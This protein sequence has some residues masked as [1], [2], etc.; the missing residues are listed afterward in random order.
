MVLFDLDNTLS[1][2]SWSER[3]ALPG[4][5]DQFGVDCSGESAGRYLAV[6]KQLAAPL[7]HRLERGELQLDTLN[8][9]RF[10]LFVAA[11]GI[12]VD[13]ALL[14]PAYLG[15]LSRS[16]GLLPGAR[17]LLDELHGE[18]RLGV[19]TNG[20]SAVQ[21]PRLANFDLEKYFEAVVISSEI[22][23]AKPSIDFFAVAFD[24]LGDP[25]PGSVLVVGDS[26]SS[27]IAGG[28]NAGTATC[29]FNPLGA[30]P[31]ATPTGPASSGLNSSG[32]VSCLDPVVRLAR[33]R[34]ARC[35]LAR[36]RLA[37]TRLA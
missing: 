12:D 23:H 24:Q 1:D 31:P 26:L 20:Y 19:V 30:P 6:F 36:C 18:V 14:A 33:C 3:E 21:R 25:D 28:A 13:P 22:G 8:D 7:W 11:T 29:W 32:P 16:G 4:V 10:R 37:R 2:F 17:E 35:R 5:L 15:W 34:L 9:E 27:D